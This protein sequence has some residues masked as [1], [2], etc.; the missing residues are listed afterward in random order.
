MEVL[1][2]SLG[3][4]SLSTPIPHI[5]AAEV[6]ANPLDV[7]RTYLAQILAEIAG[8]DIGT[9]YTSIQWPNNISNG[10]LSVTIP[11]LRPGCKPVELLAELVNKVGLLV[12]HQAVSKRL[13]LRVVSE[14]P[15]PVRSSSS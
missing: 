12:L 8:C 3:S 7:C 9:A 4:L 13:T 5:D 1:E 15:R 14:R 2:Q 10:D 11:K 6:L